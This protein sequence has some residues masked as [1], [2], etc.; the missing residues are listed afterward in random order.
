MLC[1][2]LEL[3]KPSVECLGLRLTTTAVLAY[4]TDTRQI[5]LVTAACNYMKPQ[6]TA[7]TLFSI[8][9]DVK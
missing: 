3:P 6:T 2:M 5:R 8:N 4:F 7:G 9:F 1:Q